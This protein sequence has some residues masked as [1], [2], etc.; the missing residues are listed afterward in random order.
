[1]WR[2]FNSSN[3]RP[4][5]SPS[6]PKR[7]LTVMMKKRWAL[8][9]P[10]LTSKIEES[11]RISKS[12]VKKSS[13]GRT[14]ILTP[15]MNMKAVLAN[16]H[17]LLRVPAFAR[18]PLSVRF[19][20]EDLYA[21]WEAHCNTKCGPLKAV[22]VELDLRKSERSESPLPPL[23]PPGRRTGGK[24]KQ[25]APT[26]EGGLQGLDITNPHLD[27]HMQKARDL[28]RDGDIKCGVCAGGFA[29][30][31][32]APAVVCPH[33]FCNHVAHLRCLS[34]VFLQMDVKYQVLPTEGVCP[35]CKKS[36]K[37]VD[38]V[39]EL[40][41]RTRRKPEAPRKKGVSAVGIVRG[42]D[43]EDSEEEEAEMELV[44]SDNELGLL[45]IVAHIS[46]SDSPLSVADSDSEASD[47]SRGSAGKSK[48]KKSRSG[49]QGKAVDT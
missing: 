7:S 20:V 19:F 24:V 9:H 38:L 44:P 48:R 39:K 17:L 1:M 47:R 28:L 8:Q 22:E 35:E 14:R 10:N 29:H 31:G 40:S 43:E 5:S 23:P 11:Q 34:Q 49:D 4:P 18:W 21:L 27:R 3:F 36:T 26:G 13:S 6:S 16:I 30:D 15:R 45:D 33:A 37:W 41:S 12:V 42:E 25:F 46:D 32:E 2:L